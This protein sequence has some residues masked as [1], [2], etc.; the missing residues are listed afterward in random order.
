[1]VIVY[2]DSAVQTTFVELV[3]FISGSRNVMRKGKMQAKMMEMRAAMK[4]ESDDG[5]DYD[6]EVEAE[7]QTGR[8][9]PAQK[10]LSSG[11]KEGS[12]AVEDPGNADAENQSDFLI[13][14]LRFVSTRTMGRIALR[15]DNASNTPDSRSLRSGVE[16]SPG[17]F[18]ELDKGLEWSQGQCEHAAHQF[19]RDGECS[20]EIENI[21]KKLAEVMDKAEKEVERL[22]G[23]EKR[24]NSAAL[25][26]ESK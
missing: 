7:H 11:N 20:M 18:D 2:Y 14:N 6:E 21:K 9:I 4:M 10:N 24:K 8:L 25:S 23:E 13:R 19:L 5:D 16:D 3:K 17:V 12:S 15:V 22:E 1:M 26:A